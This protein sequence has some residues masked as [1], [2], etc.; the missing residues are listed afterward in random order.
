MPLVLSGTNGVSSD[1]T[2]W[3]LQ[4][5]TSGYAKHPNTP[6]FQ[7]SYNTVTSGQVVMNTY[8]SYSKVTHNSAGRITVPTSGLYFIWH[9]GL[10]NGGSGSC[11]TEIRHNG[12]AIGGSRQQ[13]TGNSNDNFCVN[14][15][16]PLS[17]NDYIEFWV[18]QGAAHGNADYNSCGL[19]Y[20][21]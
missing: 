18:I 17:A 12:S 13:D 8:V 16:K 14:I 9:N 11:Q 5:Q 4:P 21:G 19:F 20:I 15:I 2:N 7:G 6:Y 1:G 3:A 10:G